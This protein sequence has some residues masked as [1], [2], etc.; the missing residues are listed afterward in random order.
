PY[1]FC[2]VVCDSGHKYLRLPS[3]ISVN[4][5]DCAAHARWCQPRDVQDSCSELLT[6]E[7]ISALCRLRP[8]G[9]SD[10]QRCGYCR[11]TFDRYGID[12]LIA[13]M[14]AK[15]ATKVT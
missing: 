7:A 13:V 12:S 10:R 9:A 14:E 11:I 8:L 1:P 3:V 15:M 2:V 5:L 4:G 6:P